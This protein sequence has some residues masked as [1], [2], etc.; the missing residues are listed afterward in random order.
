MSARGRIQNLGTQRAVAALDEQELPRSANTAARTSSI[1]TQALALYQ[2]RIR[3]F[4]PLRNKP[5]TG[6]ES[7]PELK[8]KLK[9]ERCSGYT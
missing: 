6:L 5:E 3:I 8:P 4:V 2:Y 9:H 7:K 1:P